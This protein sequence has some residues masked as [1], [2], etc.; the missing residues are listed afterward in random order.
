M[1][2][3]LTRLAQRIARIEREV[4]ASR[5]PQ[6]GQSSIDEGSLDVTDPT[7]GQP[8]VQIGQQFDGTFAV[9]PVIGP[10]PPTPSGPIL[11]PM[12]GALIVRWDGTFED[13]SV[14]PMDFARIEVHV[15]TVAGFTPG[16]ETLRGT[17][18]TALGGEAGAILPAGVL[19]YVKLVTR[20]LA[21]KASPPSIEAAETPTVVGV[22]QAVLDQINADLADAASAVQAV[23]D[24]VDGIPALIDA[25]K[26]E[27]LDGSIPRQPNAVIAEYVASDTILARHVKARE[28]TAEHLQ[29]GSL[30]SASG[31]IGDLSANDIT[32]G[33]LDADLVSVVNLR[34]ESIAS[35]TLSAVDIDGVTITGSTIEGSEYLTDLDAA[36]GAYW[37]MVNGRL[38]A[39]SGDINDAPGGLTVNESNVSLTTP[40][41]WDFGILRPPGFSMYK[42]DASA[43]PNGYPTYADISAGIIRLMP[44]EGASYAPYM[45]V[46]GSAGTKD[47]QR[48]IRNYTPT[49]F[50]PD[51]Y[52]GSGVPAMT[53]TDK[54]ITA[55][56]MRSVSGFG[57]GSFTKTVAGTQD[58]ANAAG[59]VFVAPPS[60]TVKI[61][62]AGFLRAAAD[63]QSTTLF[64]EIRN[65][66]VIKSGTVWQAG[67]PNL[68]LANYNAQ[69]IKGDHAE[70]VTGLTP[71][72]TYNAYVQVNGQ[73]GAICT[74]TSIL[75]EPSF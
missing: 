43:A 52:S 1:S 65:G 68:S 67:N 54:G 46:G 19:H 62:I 24:E 16:M 31:V 74:N 72:N 42:G 38:E 48:I 6:L 56:R 60:G 61:T 51:G 25:A 20:S 34:A 40:S 32:T 28:L 63:G 69:F 2:S 47:A 11:E 66:G 73:V 44:S 8:A 13:G 50:L 71:G 5:T 49:E 41:P 27:A 75:I 55:P 26:T 70:L 57:S 45:E 22:D 64:F 15:S 35:G 30:T 29:L 21:G 9:T 7:T 36:T 17:I 12:P 10:V 53:V 58:F 14:S 37:R 59:V 3:A 18:N 4:A 33:T 23:S 39:Y